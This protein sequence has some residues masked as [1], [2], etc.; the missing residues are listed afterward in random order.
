MSQFDIDNYFANRQSL[1]GQ[2]KLDAL[3]TA[4]ANKVQ[5]LAESRARDALAAPVLE[6]ERAAAAQSWIG[7]LGLDTSSVV[8]GAGNFLANA[9]EGVVTVEKNI[10][11]GIHD[12]RLG[13]LSAT[14]PE[15]PVQA[16]EAFA[17]HRSGKATSAD[18]QLLNS[19][20]QRG[21]RKG[22]ADNPLTYMQT[23]SAKQG[24]IDDAAAVRSTMDVSS[25]VDRTNQQGLINDLG[26]GYD[27]SAAQVSKGWADLKSGKALS[28]SADVVSGLAGAL[29]NIGSAAVNNPQAA[30]EFIANNAPQL[31]LAA[32]GAAGM[33]GT[34]IPYA[35]NAFGEGIATYQAKNGGRM[36]SDAEMAV[37]AG[38]AATLGVAETLGD[39]ITLGAGKAGKAV[40]GAAEQ[41]A[42]RAGL[43]K[44][45]F[46]PALDNAGV[47]I[48]GAGLTSAAG[49]FAT[50]AYQ[51]AMENEIKGEAFDLKDT[52]V[53]GAIGAIVGGGLAGG[54]RTV[55]EVAK[56]TPE[57]MA[58]RAAEAVKIAADKASFKKAADENN[59]D[60]F[61]N[62]KDKKNFNPA[63]AVGALLRHA[64]APTTAPEVRKG[65]LKRAGDIVAGLEDKHEDL[66]NKAD[67]FSADAIQET[68][69]TI[70]GFQEM[71]N[72]VDPTDTTQVTK[73]GNLITAYKDKL[74]D[75]T[76]VKA[77]T[78]AISAYTT[79][80]NQLTMSRE[81]IAKLSTE[82]QPVISTEEVKTAVAEANTVTDK[83]DTAAVEASRTKVTGLINL[84]MRS[85]SSLTEAQARQLAD[86]MNNTLEESERTYLRAFS[87]ARLNENKLARMNSVSN[88]ILNGDTKNEGIL[89][90][91]DK[92]AS[93]IA[94]SN[95]KSADRVLKGITDFAVDHQ[96]KSTALQEAFALG[97]G[98][99]IQKNDKTGEWLVVAPGARELMNPVAL[100]KNGGFEIEERSPK[101]VATI[102]AEALALIAAA[103][104][105]SLAH[106]MKFGGKAKSAVQSKSSAAPTDAPD[107]SSISLS[108]EMRERREHVE[109][110]KPTP[111]LSPVT[112][113]V[114]ETKTIPSGNTEATSVAKPKA[115]EA[116]QEVTQRQAGASAASEAQV[117]E[118]TTAKA[119]VEVEKSIISSPAASGTSS[120][121]SDNVQPTVA[122]LP[123]ADTFPASSLDG[124]AAG[125]LGLFKKA[126]AKGAEL[127]YSK[128]HLIADYF[129]QDAGK[130][131]NGTL[132]PLASVPNFLSTLYSSPKTI[133][134]FLKSKITPEQS[135]VIQEFMTNATDWQKRI[136]LGLIRIQDKNEGQKDYRYKDLA[137]F[138][139]NE[140]DDVDM[141]ENVKT[142]I[143]YAATAAMID[144]QSSGRLA[145][146]KDINRFL[147]N[148]EDAELP[149]GAYKLLA[150]KGTLEGV[151]KASW[152]QTVM[153]SLGLKPLPDAPKNL[154]PTLEAAMG[155]MV[156]K[157]LLDLDVIEQSTVTMFE[158]DQYIASEI[159]K[160]NEKVSVKYLVENAKKTGVELTQQE[161]D[162]VNSEQFSA[163]KKKASMVKFVRLVRK[164]EFAPD[165]TDKN[166]KYAAH[167]LVARIVKA[168]KNTQSVL[169]KLFSVESHYR[170]PSLTPVAFTQVKAGDG[171]MNIP[172]TGLEILKEE[173]KS[174]HYLR[175]DLWNRVLGQLSPDAALAIMGFEEITPDMHMFR[176]LSVQAKNDG[177]EREYHGFMEYIQGTLSKSSPDPVEALLQPMHLEHD[178][179][180]Q[181][182][183]GIKTNVVNPQSSKFHRAMLYRKAWDTVVDTNSV[184]SMN[185][186][187]LRVGE[188]LG[189]KTD[190]QGNAVSLAAIHALFDPKNTDPDKNAKGIA[191]QAAVK[192][193]QKTKS[194]T[195]LTAADEE[196][197]LAGVK[198]GGEAA[199]SMDALLSMA[200]YYEALEKGDTTFNI[201][202]MAEVDGV[203]N[204]PM[205]S[206]ML[207]GAAR[208]VKSLF[209]LLN[210]GGFFQQ[211][212]EQNQYNLWR[213]AADHLDLYENTIKNVLK[214]VRELRGVPGKKGIDV[215]DL[216]AVLTF[217]G[218]LDN[219][220]GSINKTGR[221]IIKTP[222]TA[223]VF[224]ASVGSSVDS[225]ADKFV[226]AVYKSM[227][228][229][230]KMGD[231]E[232]AAKRADILK[233]LNHLG[234]QWPANMDVQTMLDTEFTDQQVKT[235]K[236]AFTYTL[237]KAVRNTIATDFKDFLE[238]RDALN[239][240][241]QLAST[242]YSAVYEGMR[243]EM[244]QKLMLDGLM[245]YK[246][247]PEKTEFGVTTPEH[248]EPL[249]D[250]NAKQEKILRE[251]VAAL[252]P[253]MH[254]AMSKDS[255]ELDAGL[256]I[257]KTERKFGTRDAYTGR[258]HFATPLKGI[259]K[260][261]KENKAT[262]DR[263][264]ETKQIKVGVEMAAL[265]THA[266][267]SMISHYA[268]KLME[269]LNVHDA[270]GAGLGIIQQAAKNLNQATWNA[271][272]GYSPVTEMHEA[273]MRT[274][275][276][277]GLMIE[278]KTMPA[279]VLD[280]LASAMVAF[281]EATPGDVKPSPKGMI[282]LQA[283]ISKHRAFMAD[284]MKL[285]AMAMMEAI[286]Q[287]AM[288]GGNHMVTPEER[289]MAVKL[290][291]KLTQYLSPDDATTMAV[292]DDALDV[293]IE[294]VSPSSKTKTTDAP[295][296]IAPTTVQ[297]LF[298]NSATVTLKQAVGVLN[299]S[300]LNEFD[301]RLLRVVERSIAPD[302]IIRLVT[303]NNKGDVLDAG[304]KGAL[305]WYVSKDGK[306]EIN[307]NGVGLNK[308]TLLHELTHAAL[309]RTIEDAQTKG[310]GDAFELVQELEALRLQAVTYA[311][312]KGIEK[313][314]TEALKNVHEMVSW[315]MT[316]TVFQDQILKKVRMASTTAG[317]KWLS[318]MEAFI[319]K[320]VGL[321]FK[322]KNASMERGLSILITNASGLLNAASQ[323]K[324]VAANVK[325]NMTVDPVTGLNEY[326]THDIY[327]ALDQNSNNGASIS[328]GFDTHLQDVLESITSKLYGPFGSFKEAVMKGRNVSPE[329]VYAEAVANN[330]AP[331][332][333]EAFVAGINMTEKET[334][335]F[336][337]VEAA[338]RMGINTVGGSTFAAYRE[339]DKL[340]NEVRAKVLVEDFYPGDWNN[341]TAIEQAE[342]KAVHDFI[343]TIK[344]GPDGRAEY[345]ARFAAM[346][347]ASER[348]NA[349]LKTATNRKSRDTTGM[350]FNERLQVWI[351]SL[352]D[353]FAGKMTRTYEG[354]DADAKITALVTQLVIN[355][356]KVQAKLVRPAT[357][358]ETLTDFADELVDGKR[359]FLRDKIEKFG[360]LDFFRQN[361]SGFLRGAGAVMSTYGGH[362]VKVVMKG[363]KLFRDEHFRT[364]QGVIAALINE[365]KGADA[366]N[367]IFHF[368]LRMTKLIEGQRKDLKTGTSKVVLGSFLKGGR[369]LTKKHKEGLSQLLRTDAA[370]LLD[371][372]SMDKLASMLNDSAVLD[373]EIDALKAKFA[374]TG[375]VARFTDFYVMSSQALG[376]EIATGK[377][378]SEH[379]LLNAHNIARLAGTGKQRHVTESEA[380]A[381]E[382][383]IDPLVSLYAFKYMKG[384][385]KDALKE[386]F[387][388]EGARVTTDKGNGIE[389]MLMTHKALQE[390][391]KS[392]LFGD[393]KALY[394]KGYVPEIYDPYLAVMVAD[395]HRDGANPFTLSQGEQL[396]AQ[397]YRKGASVGIDE[398]DPDGKSDM[399]I[400]TLRDGGMM[401]RVTGVISYTDMHAK[402]DRM[403]NGN[404]SPDSYTGQLNAQALASMRAA[405]QKGIDAM[406][407]TKNFDPT[408]VDKTY[409][410]P[411]MNA[412]GEVANYRYLM[413]GSTKDDVLKRDNRFE[414]LLGTLAGNTFDKVESPVQNRKA[415]QALNHQYK[416]EF[417]EIP[418]SYMKVGPTSTDPELREIYRL[419]PDSTKEAIQDIWGTEG[420][421]VRV[422]LLDHM[423]GYRK[424]SI[425]DAFTTKKEERHFLQKMLVEMSTYAF[426]AKAPLRIRQAEDVWQAVVQATKSNLVVR[427]WSTMSG[428]LRSN[429]SQLVLMG[430]TPAAIFKHHRV[431]LK[432]AWA[433]KK[434]SEELF[435]LNQQLES[436]YFAP[437]N[438]EAKVKDR[439]AQLENAIARN[440]VKP[441]IDAGLMPTIVEDVAADEDMH[442][443]KS[444]MAERLTELTDSV[445]PNVT[446]VAKWLLMT[447]DSTPYKFM[448]YATQ[449]SDFL[450]RYTLY[451]HATTRA[452][453]PLAHEEA[454]QLASDAFINYDLPTHRKMQ[455][456]NDTG[457]IFFTKYYV[458]IQ[459]MIVRLYKE[460]PGRVM[461]MLA[462]EAWLG[463]Q[464]TV[465][466]SSMLVR[467]SNP[468]NAGALN[469][470]DSV[471]E[472]A[473][474]KAL[475]SPFSGGGG[476]PNL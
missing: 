128:R 60:I 310:K 426:D 112:P 126:T 313:R 12:A 359:E 414:N 394:M 124:S 382:A 51:T 255:G 410:T 39:K 164:A 292:I 115:K 384:V 362:R 245:E 282:G 278:D 357:V 7:Q 172:N 185:N 106:E 428:N 442:S 91:R 36:P 398:H 8:G 421:M 34:N 316:N 412:N 293:V 360:K 38:K 54:M 430:M 262:S 198:A 24:A 83:A 99:Q 43:K 464:P 247:V 84:S 260:P 208:D 165:Q 380:V 422:D 168:N 374:K 440:P 468:L 266:F 122:S 386:V 263:G 227:E 361:T 100:K 110:G 200:L 393:A 405:K 92:M 252:E 75:Q 389:M 203:T 141:D 257:G 451:Q 139:V 418:E 408:R 166:A 134:Q 53:G 332:A 94:A 70:A 105:M 173:N 104:E 424:L 212:S 151:L 130:A 466:D 287:Y 295:S 375:K 272:L 150:D 209:A 10:A 89:T 11:A 210:R 303:E 444:M 294:K 145:T 101:P 327:A 354:Q 471:G 406:F 314:F 231:T 55:A 267:D 116:K 420:M 235:L 349:L 415:V 221:D 180:V 72:N 16:R 179:W 334:F 95:Q 201:Q 167:P 308:E 81:M 175:L 475:F 144:L 448:S 196:T 328:A 273:Y 223:I 249:H 183:V 66:K 119:D 242:V 251:Q 425:A 319:S 307:I 117:A 281:A 345:L 445:N 465:L 391:A 455:Y 193:L 298:T 178:M 427:S 199:H 19:D 341:A 52:Y 248:N 133:K 432:G 377:D 461:L 372:Y 233:N 301:A 120:P 218:N 224:S 438:T 453:N 76:D 467:F 162:Y 20:P 404:V 470:F 232:K 291:T 289:A 189:I 44:A 26:D 111:P 275:R 9:A 258:T 437:G 321:L 1:G 296:D 123:A 300:G 443:Y 356:A 47:R 269:V 190:K 439:I 78:V 234:V 216:D 367:V 108:R 140:D 214:N 246:V 31:V 299:T 102:K 365:A 188:G 57:H 450:S 114:E 22:L 217:T 41:A 197:L 240:T 62:E 48:A 436:R 417:A 416:L 29:V 407:T 96:A 170:E 59:P 50:E 315:G 409:M 136:E 225:M 58:E 88:V 346:G 64:E 339:L 15:E 241:A 21:I 181:Q 256:F 93:A 312:S 3:A 161:Q 142:A 396:E 204:G 476:N 419:L 187:Y 132:R 127:V 261:G 447:E 371:N 103:K 336:D 276:N 370:Y 456:A 369:D 177:L 253:V 42:A 2:S 4:S 158:L 215:D 385:H 449:I 6:A 191:M 395:P 352:L 207:M 335:V 388:S 135:A 67:Y 206:H 454:V 131:E 163:E 220:N 74:A 351:E 452:K 154:L 344:Q 337:Q 254:T 46:G 390:E 348:F 474:I 403:H 284:D 69:D 228:V 146:Q 97:L 186:F 363:W 184:D 211:G 338:V 429:W 219:E 413:Q 324:D 462:G 121:A 73:I 17:R 323:N 229:M 350:P 169:S 457:L 25:I 87:E 192:V 109:V 399:H 222:L 277:L 325:A 342:A 270:H 63:R 400:Y 33:A 446:K 378:T 333:S 265:S 285:A 49:E 473:V 280:K 82:V 317:N 329:Q 137:Q 381:T 302:L 373:K 182:R 153:E 213:G 460:H 268:A 463:S 125:I 326:N 35:I 202:M 149:I 226:E 305:G 411:L 431:A 243:E 402:G 230:A 401:R 27:T 238:Q 379:T 250:L 113:S 469:Y 347:M 155:A 259:G 5:Q 472:T 174:E 56:A 306:H 288:E 366:S 434:D 23:L 147:G 458:R 13:Y 331:Y 129:K 86:N 37:M 71:V 309:A 271:L 118:V 279:P 28:G 156:F 244:L 79:L 98:A 194:M 205:L 143:S 376:Y 318:G 18:L 138:F 171:K 353:W 304:E 80:D 90:W 40:S 441:L 107:I 322:R 387:A 236:D 148:R 237:G 176:R 195:G 297:D 355:E 61:L 68:K 157:L 358:V 435:A 239:R 159:K 433:Y 290:R 152:G 459:R 423:F 286:D 32:G 311:E 364:Q 320:L 392:K 30:L 14:N 397:G 383:I 274:M 160:N 77:S 264:Y 65:N 283:T 340:F 368:M 45:L 343:F 330:V 85:P